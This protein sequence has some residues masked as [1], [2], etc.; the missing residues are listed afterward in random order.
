LPVPVRLQDPLHDEFCGL[1]KEDAKLYYAWFLKQIPH[2]LA[3][4]ENTVCETSGYYDWKCDYSP[5]SLDPL[6]QW[7]ANRVSKRLRVKSEIDEI[8]DRGPAW[9]KYMPINNWD[10][11]VETYSFCFDIGIYF[12]LVL[13]KNVPD[14]KWKLISK[15]KRHVFLNQPVLTG[16]KYP[17]LNP[18]SIMTVFARKLL[19][20]ASSGDRLEELYRIWSD[21]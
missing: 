14:V 6:G 1:S 11:S 2:R 12:A 8:Y 21:S 18:F 4:L 3:V 15:A 19:T 13:Q 10:L 17:E 16:L 7:F 9:F 20:K 5:K